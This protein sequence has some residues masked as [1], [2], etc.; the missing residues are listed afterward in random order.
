MPSRKHILNEHKFDKIDTEEKA[1][2]LGFIMADGYIE[3]ESRLSFILQKKPDELNLLLR[4]QSFLE[5]DNY[6]NERTIYDKRDFVSESYI[7]RVTSKVLCKRLKQLKVVTQKTGK[8][9]I[10]RGVPKRLYRHFI[11]G[12]F[13]GDG[14]L[15]KSVNRNYLRMKIG[16]CSLLILEQIRD[17]VQEK[18]GY[19]ISIYE[20]KKY[21]KMFYL[22][23]SNSKYAVA[24]FCKLIYR[25]SKIY[26][27]RKFNQAKTTFKI[28]PPK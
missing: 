20:D 22:L 23:E 17:Y 6:I 5:T 16:S 15:G 13:D 8:E 14:S 11:R 26:L 12:F 18:T 4:L 27:E 1:Y 25:R 2:W 21:K 24:E 28:C 10:P 19:R 9:C 7:F 3:N